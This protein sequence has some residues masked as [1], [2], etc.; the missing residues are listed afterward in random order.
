MDV[1]SVWLRVFFFNDTATT[2]IYTLSLH[3]A[4][5]IFAVLDPLDEALLELRRRVE[6]DLPAELDDVRVG[7]DLFV[8]D[9]EVQPC[10]SRGRGLLGNGISTRIATCTESRARRGLGGLAA[11]AFGRRLLGLLDGRLGF[12]LLILRR[13]LDRLL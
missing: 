8:V 13:E 6:V 7:V 4:L 3:D 12:L 10:S 11:T 5:P 1:H 2:E 9:V